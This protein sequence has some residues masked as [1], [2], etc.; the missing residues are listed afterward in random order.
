[1]PGRASYESLSASP[2]ASA[3]E[4]DTPQ[5]GSEG[6]RSSCGVLKPVALVVLVCSAVVSM[7]GTLTTPDAPPA[8]A[9]AGGAAMVEAAGAAAPPAAATELAAAAASTGHRFVARNDY[10][11]TRSASAAA[12]YPFLR[13]KLLVEPHRR[14]AIEFTPAPGLR[15]REGSMAW[16]VAQL[17]NCAGARAPVTGGARAFVAR[18]DGAYSWAVEFAALGDYEVSVSYGRG[19]GAGEH[20]GER[21]VA[22]LVCR[23]VRR[24]LREMSAAD[25]GGFFDAIKTMMDVGSEEGEAAYGAKYRSMDHFVALHLDHG[26]RRNV[27]RL[28]D[29]L[30][31]LTQHMALTAE[32]EASVQAIA[33]HLAAP[34]W[35]F[36]LDWSLANRSDAPFEAL[37]ALDVWQA[38]WFGTSSGPWHTVEE[39][40]FAYTTVTL[41]RSAPVT[42]PYGFLRAPWNVNKSPYLTRTHGFC[43][44]TSTPWIEP[45]LTPTNAKFGWPSCRVHWQMIYEVSTFY[46]WAWYV[47]YFPHGTVHSFIGGYTN[48]GFDE[49]PEFFNASAA[50][51]AGVVPDAAKAAR[52]EKL[53]GV[54]GLHT[55]YFPKNLWRGELAEFPEYCSAD[56]PQ[57]ECHMQCTEK[58]D[59]ASFQEL[60]KSDAS[61]FVGDWADT[62]ADADWEELVADICSTPWSP[63]EQL[64]AA[65]PIDPSFW[66]IHPALDRLLHW[67]KIAQPFTDA[68]WADP[69]DPD[70]T[71]YCMVVKDIPGEEG[72][73]GHHAFDTTFFETHHL[74][75]TDGSFKHSYLTNGEIFALSELDSYALP[76]VYDHFVWEHCE[77][78]GYMF[79]KADELDGLAAAAAAEE[80]AAAASAPPAAAIAD[81]AAAVPAADDAAAVPAADD[82]AA[83]PAADADDS[84]PGVAQ[85]FEGS[86]WYIYKVTA[87]VRPQKDLALI[88]FINRYLMPGTTFPTGTRDASVGCNNT[89]L[90]GDY[91]VNFTYEG[92]ASVDNQLHWVNGPK[93]NGAGLAASWIETILEATV[94]TSRSRGDTLV[95]DST[96]ATF[97][98]FMHNKVQLY[99]DDLSGFAA[100]LDADRVPH[101][102]RK[103]TVARDARAGAARDVEMGHLLIPIEGRAFELVGPLASLDASARGA[104]GLWGASECPNAHALADDFAT[105]EERFAATANTTVWTDSAR[106]GARDARPQPMLAQVHVALSPNRTLSAEDT[107][108]AH[109]DA[110]TRAKVEV[111]ADEDAS[112]C[113]VASLT[114]ASMPGVTVKYV[115]NAHPSLPATGLLA[116]YEQAWA[117]EHANAFLTPATTQLPMNANWDTFL[118]T[119]IGMMVDVGTQCDGDLAALTSALHAADVAYA[120]R[121]EGGGIHLYTGYEGTTSWEYNLGMTCTTEQFGDICTCVPEN[122]AAVYERRF[123]E[124]TCRDSS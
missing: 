77:E 22:S 108:L 90:G 70:A 66:P 116:E 57:A 11:V 99:V 69:D 63:G 50:D 88:E 104:Y 49:A 48:C 103:S 4:V 105:L 42:S 55:L 46:D 10:N 44:S 5:W 113:G 39:G 9:A 112:A 124:S 19:D 41:N 40:R 53:L 30:G 89:H 2:W 107:A 97:N 65:S 31:F 119:H 123:G 34:Y 82:A 101:L 20:V 32:F 18:A 85:G 60:L 110:F 29:G 98:A 26:A 43:G 23:Y 100:R 21:A 120:A 94:G 106:G 93:L 14:T 15:V 54:F 61:I 6:R 12:D 67:K 73:H 111:H 92:T 87:T 45:T 80:A 102:K 35:D 27:D 84:T 13:G 33:P 7:R 71:E 109:L 117:T 17:T 76:Y 86:D 68:G 64:E 38:D 1:M 118:D 75:A 16:G 122:S 96:E 74:D 56:T 59:S 52:V 36:T 95:Y 72:C 24:S 3:E 51:R 79:K 81:D 8:V 47:P 28:H 114:W 91:K 115:R 62:L 83:V 58:A 121:N 25:R 37:F 78:E